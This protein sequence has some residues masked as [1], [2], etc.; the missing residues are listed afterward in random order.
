MALLFVLCRGSSDASTPLIQ[1]EW[2]AQVSVKHIIASNRLWSLFALPTVKQ[3]FLPVEHRV[4]TYLGGERIVTSPVNIPWNTLVLCSSE[5]RYEVSDLYFL[6]IIRI[7]YHV[8]KCTRVFCQKRVQ[9]TLRYLSR[10][11]I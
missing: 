1:K 8:F 4:P 6:Y 10:T 9:Y 2:A 5:S 3:R 7:C 11:Q